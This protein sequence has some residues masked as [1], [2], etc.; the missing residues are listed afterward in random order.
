MNWLDKL[1]VKLRRFAVPYRKVYFG[2]AEVDSFEGHMVCRCKIIQHELDKD[3][4]RVQLIGLGGPT[5][6][7]NLCIKF[8]DGDYWV[9]LPVTKYRPV[10]ECHEAIIPLSKLDALLTGARNGETR[11]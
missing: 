7:T 8:C 2:I 3:N 10:E 11:F 6:H 5:L 1:S 4:Y 9:N